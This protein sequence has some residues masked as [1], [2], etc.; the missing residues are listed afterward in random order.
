MQRSSLPSGRREQKADQ[1]DGPGWG[2]QATPP[3]RGSQGELTCWFNLEKV[4]TGLAL[5]SG[6]GQ[7]NPSPFEH[8]FVYVLI[9]GGGNVEL[10]RRKLKQVPLFP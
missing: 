8:E 10:G 4:W 9:V 3:L 2:R 1:S 7:W 6:L 5:Q